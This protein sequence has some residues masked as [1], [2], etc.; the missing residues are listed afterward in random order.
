MFNTLQKLYALI[1]YIRTTIPGKELHNGYLNELYTPE[2]VD[3]L[4]DEII[5]A[6]V[7]NTDKKT[8]SASIGEIK[9]RLSLNAIIPSL[10]DPSKSDSSFKFLPE[11][12]KSMIR[13]YEGK[14][15]ANAI[16]A[17]QPRT[18]VQDALS[19]GGELAGYFVS[20]YTK[21]VFTSSEFAAFDEK[22]KYASIDKTRTAIKTARSI[23][24]TLKNFADS[25]F[26]GTFKM[27]PN[28]SGENGTTIPVI[29]LVLAKEDKQFSGKSNL[30]LFMQVMSNIM[31]PLGLSSPK[32]M[33][34]Q[35]KKILLEKDQYDAFKNYFVMFVS[36]NE[37]N[38]T[39]SG[40]AHTNDDGE[41][42]SVFNSLTYGPES[43]NSDNTDITAQPE[44]LTPT[45]NPQMAIGKMLETVT[46][47]HIDD[48]IGKEDSEHMAV[49]VIMSLIGQIVS[50]G[51]ENVSALENILSG[52]PAGKCN[53]PICQ[54]KGEIQ[55]II[56]GYSNEL[57]N[58]KTV[59]FGN[60]TE[61]TN[62]AKTLY[63]MARVAKLDVA[64]LRRGSSFNPKIL[65]NGISYD[66]SGFDG[67]VEKIIRIAEDGEYIPIAS[68]SG[69]SDLSVTI[70]FLENNEM[71]DE[72]ERKASISSDAP[73]KIDS[74]K[75]KPIP[76]GYNE[77]ISTAMRNC[78]YAMNTND[79]W[80]HMSQR[81]LG[82]FSEEDIQ[83][84]DKPSLAEGKDILLKTLQA[85]A[86]PFMD[87][88]KKIGTL[89]EVIDVINSGIGENISPIDST[90]ISKKDLANYKSVIQQTLSSNSHLNQ[91]N[92]SQQ[93]FYSSISLK[94]NTVIDNKCD[95]IQETLKA[96]GKM[97]AETKQSIY[98][99]L[100][101]DNDTIRIVEKIFSARTLPETEDAK[102]EHKQHVLSIGTLVESIIR[103][104][105][106]AIRNSD[107]IPPAFE[108]S[109]TY[110]TAQTLI[111]ISSGQ[112]T[113]TGKRYTYGGSPCEK[114]YLFNAMMYDI[115]ARSIYLIKHSNGTDDDGIISASEIGDIK[116]YI[117]INS[118]MTFN[119][120]THLKSLLTMVKS[121]IDLL[122]SS[123]SSELIPIISSKLSNSMDS[124]NIQSAMEKI[125]ITE[126]S[127][128]INLYGNSSPSIKSIEAK[129]RK[130]EDE[131]LKSRMSEDKQKLRKTKARREVFGF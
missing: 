43:S 63:A 31:S 106:D 119:Y 62:F 52:E 16:K 90:Q 103:L 104:Y 105:N 122:D 42:S 130:K 17:F 53:A 55:Q 96:A 87:G 38:N 13:L 65:R 81:E 40:M 18:F 125:S 75:R 54:Q 66:L 68:Y 3:L 8:S 124:D 35:R 23:V 5:N 9:K 10:T 57:Q 32:I 61:M 120:A 20:I 74:I 108:Q 21:S 60:E 111:L 92:V 25:R 112:M 127:L 114:E 34:G 49:P 123:I 11:T 59:E 64:N 115:L 2:T 58:N 100:G 101:K 56:D 12:P 36:K 129:A 99:E 70:E 102:D 72:D 93:G 6:M 121:R 24:D 39:E 85:A 19:T 69:D 126:A 30:E 46:N 41:S 4:T 88:I 128:R 80:R 79:T 76:S 131:E 22:Y 47:G 73:E 118:G 45:N 107:D 82:S 97:N 95:E 44:T 27:N 15:I 78:G 94:Y 28:G 110:P 50:A 84:P 91:W 98:A 77:S 48:S 29:E 116:K 109:Y 7:G 113:L 1:Y 83:Y 33:D 89:N 37:F 26:D 14:K 51:P 71:L 67:I 117:S 86:A